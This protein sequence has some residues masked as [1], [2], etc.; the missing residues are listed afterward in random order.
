MDLFYIPRRFHMPTPC[1]SW[2]R[3][4]HVWQPRRTAEKLSPSPVD[5]SYIRSRYCNSRQGNTAPGD[6]LDPPNVVIL[7]I[8]LLE[9]LFVCRP[10][11]EIRDQWLG[12]EPRPS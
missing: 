2:P 8:L 5:L 4:A 1:G 7:T 3:Y 11:E 10:S 6:I 9:Y 12:L